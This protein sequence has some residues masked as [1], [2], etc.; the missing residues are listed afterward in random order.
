MSAPASAAPRL[1][2]VHLLIRCGHQRREIGLAGRVVLGA[3]Y[4]AAQ[5]VR[6]AIM[7]ALVGQPLAKMVQRFG[8][9]LCRRVDQQ[10]DELVAPQTGN[11]VL[12]P[13]RSGQ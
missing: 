10:R 1:V 5:L 13:E 7:P 9:A 2:P 4:A 3:A 11:Q 6:W 12:T 8:Q